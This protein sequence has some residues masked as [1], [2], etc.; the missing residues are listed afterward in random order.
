MTLFQLRQSF[1]LVLTALIWGSTLVAQSVGMEAVG[2]FTFI[3]V[4]MALGALVLLPLILAARKR[5]PE[6]ALERRS[7]AYRRSLILGSLACGFFLFGGLILQQLGLCLETGVGK[8]GFI[9]SLYIVL[10]PL[11][12]LFAG[13]RPGILLWIAVAVAVAG[14][15]F[16]CVP[17]SGDFSVGTG[18][19]FVFLCSLALAFQI[20]AVS[21]FVRRVDGVELSFGQF[22][23]G[24]LLSAA[25]MLATEAPSLS[26]LET[27]AVPLLWAGV[28]SNGIACTLQVVGQR[29]MNP[30][31]ASLLMSLEGVFAVLAGWLCLGESLSA[32]ETAGCVLMG[33]AIVLAQI[34]VPSGK[35]LAALKRRIFGRS[36]AMQAAQVR[37]S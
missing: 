26:A 37:A 11:L 14:L 10:I 30:T 16:L 20:L 29:G 18:D 36:P 23:V 8:A 35:R 12:G 21:W 28:M 31:V 4:R 19:F 2:P 24:A 5:H 34:P 25:G 32:R 15:W 7:A 33:G 1:L 6:K 13:E 17:A 3:A 9:T 22:A 27:A